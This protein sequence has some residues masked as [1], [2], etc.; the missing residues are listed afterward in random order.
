MTGIYLLLGANLG[1]RE[2]NLN[3]A[4]NLLA[5]RLGCITSRSSLYETEAWGMDSAPLFINQV[6]IVES[7]IEAPATL[8]VILNIETQL[9]RVRQR[10]TQNR[11]IDIDILYYGS[12]LIELS[13]LTVP[14]PRIAERRFTLEPLVEIAPDFVHPVLKMTHM[15]LLA[16]CEDRLVV[17]KLV[18]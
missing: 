15:Q 16:S 17:R 9:G 7:S 13:N 11:T 8:E 5:K 4:A 6:L 3:H 14:H 18:K 12:D 1:D 10:H 2:L